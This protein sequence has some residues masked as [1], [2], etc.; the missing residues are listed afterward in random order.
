MTTMHGGLPPLESIASYRL[1][2]M[3]SDSE[4][5]FIDGKPNPLRIRSIL[6]STQRAPNTRPNQDQQRV[7]DSIWGGPPFKPRVAANAPY[8]YASGELIDFRVNAAGTTMRWLEMQGAKFNPFL[9]FIRFYK[10]ESFIDEFSTTPRTFFV[11]IDCTL[12]WQ[13]ARQGHISPREL[14]Q[15]HMLSYILLPVQIMTRKLR[16]QSMLRNETML[17]DGEKMCVRDGEG[18]LNAN[19]PAVPRVNRISESQETDNGIVYVIDR[20][21]V[22]S[23]LY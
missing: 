3:V 1:Y 8:P 15:Y 17:I 16:V 11:P 5:E 10:L 12:L 21:L 4:I 2:G 13:A 9:T 22:P 7:P 6:D 18:A 14:L 19:L 20:G 23:V